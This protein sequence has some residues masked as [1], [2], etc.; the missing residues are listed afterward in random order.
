MLSCKL[1]AGPD[2]LQVCTQT[3]HTD[4]I[5]NV[6]HNAHEHSMS[7]RSSLD[8]SIKIPAVHPRSLTYFLLSLLLLMLLF[9]PIIVGTSLLVALSLLP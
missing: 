9:L 1:Y 6:S 5:K 2:R 7:T 4:Q 8:E 3:P